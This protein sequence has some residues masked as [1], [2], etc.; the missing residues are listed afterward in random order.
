MITVSHL[1]KSYTLYDQKC[2]VLKDVNC[3]IAKGEVVSI[4]GPS[5][6]GKSTLLRC[7]NRLEVPDSGSIV[8]DDVDILDKKT[9]INAVRQKMGMIF[10][11]FNLFE[12]LNVLN[13]VSFGPLEVLGMNKEEAKAKAMEMLRLVGLAERD[14][15]MP[16]ELSGGQKQRVAIARSLAVSPDLLLCDEPTS[17]LDRAMTV[18]VT[19]VLKRLAQNGMT[20]II[21]TH[22][23]ELA[24]DLSNRVLFMC[25]GSIIES[26]TPQQLFENSKE[27]ATQIFVHQMRSI[28]FNI[29]SRDY[30]LYEINGMIHVFCQ[31]YSLDKKYITMQ[32]L[33]EEML[34]NILPMTGPV[35]VNVN[36]MRSK[37]EIE[38][39]FE[40]ENFKGS[41]L[42][43]PNID[44]LSL[45]LVQGM[46]SDV[47]EEEIE[48]G[49]KV[50]MVLK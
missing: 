5:G 10:Q 18:E 2:P 26:G 23:M 3:H 20:M 49:C 22:D 13:N 42:T 11:S 40:Q 17:A 48:N 45:T 30:D 39:E 8:I 6:S 46:C 47:R 15:A 35:H 33:V 43:R 21:V 25:N 36:Y 44:E 14:S 50:V 37:R 38:M 16:C 28:V 32:L 34:T 31:K 12:H 9:N 1:N 7:L 29:Q 19:S 4:I 24:R 41:L 27:R